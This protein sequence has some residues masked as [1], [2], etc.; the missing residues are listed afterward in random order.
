MNNLKSNQIK[1]QIPA[2]QSAITKYLKVDAGKQA[3]Y[4]I[5]AVSHF[6]K[7]DQQMKAELSKHSYSLSAN[8]GTI[9]HPCIIKHNLGLFTED[10]Q[11]IDEAE[12]FLRNCQ[13]IM[14]WQ[15]VKNDKDTGNFINS[16]SRP[17]KG[18]NIT[19]EINAE[20]YSDVDDLLDRTKE[21][22]M[23][24]HRSNSIDYGTDNNCE[25]SVSGEEYD[26]IAD[27]DYLIEDDQYIIFDSNGIKDSDNSEDKIIALWE[28]KD[29]KYD[30]WKNYLIQAENIELSHALENDEQLYH[31]ISRQS[32]SIYSGEIMDILD[33]LKHEKHEFSL[34][35]EINRA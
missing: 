27:I 18:L 35:I 21:Q 9:D 16:F 7:N 13:K 12:L 14:N 20:K 30:S 29:S 24:L 5:F 3:A 15:L 33:I 22:I 25:F 19:I 23:N 17:E 10:H 1:A 8:F 2:L 4:H 31:A 26:V 28:N 32:G 34:F 11:A 6:F